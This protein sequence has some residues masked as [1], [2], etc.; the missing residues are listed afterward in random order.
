MKFKLLLA[1]LLIGGR[2]FAQ[3]DTVTNVSVSSITTTTATVTATPPADIS[4]VTG[5]QLRVI[6]LATSASFIVSNSTPSFSVTG[7]S[8]CV[9]YAVYVTTLCGASQA[10]QTGRYQFTTTGC[11]TYTNKYTLYNVYGWQVP[12][13]KADSV[14]S[15]P[16]K[17]TSH[18]TTYQDSGQVVIRRADSSFWYRMKGGWIQLANTAYVD[19]AYTA[20]YGL[21]LSSNSFSVD[22]SVISTKAWRQKLA[23]SL[24]AIFLP[25]TSFTSGSVL[26]RGAA[27]ISQDNA[28]LFYDSTNNTLLVG[29]S[30][31]ISVAANRLQVSSG[32]AAAG[33]VL[34]AGASTSTT[35][36]HYIGGSSKA[37][38]AAIGN[39][40]DIITG[41]QVND[42]AFRTEGGRIIF[43]NNFG[44][45]PQWIINSS[46]NI[47]AGTDNT[48]D[49][50]ASGASRPRDVYIAR[51]LIVGGSS[52][53][54]GVLNLRAGT[55]TAGTAPLKFTSGTNLATPENG[56]IEYDG[57]NYYATS[58]GT[59]KTILTSATATA[60]ESGTYTPTFTGV[61]N[62]TSI[63]AAT[64]C[65]YIRVGNVV[66]VSGFIQLTHTTNSAQT[67]VRISLPIASNF[68][69]VN[70]C[71]GTATER[72]WEY[73]PAALSAD[74]VNDAA[75]MEFRPTGSAGSTTDYMFTFTYRI[76]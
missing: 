4:Q 37:F 19:T 41:S 6:N 51:S 66:T 25:K 14:F 24:A 1:L 68:G 46:G 50:G 43:S 27:G 12:R 65:Q 54:S 35:I 75:I 11:V 38:T 36:Y 42:Y 72:S 57:T 5:Y 15:L 49:L 18:A 10:V 30:T 48:Y 61:A 9:T 45:S 32:S 71:A 8:S 74:V 34:N 44:A 26:F 28:K 39:A 29:S 22:S 33:M 31:R 60:V 16:I 3:C 55:S 47:L 21:S 62:I 73:N 67:S 76:I 17:D 56:A 20:G 64:V 13:L 53:L 63:S 7:L 2:S 59:R 23:D 52:T 70:E 40:G 58:G 69:G